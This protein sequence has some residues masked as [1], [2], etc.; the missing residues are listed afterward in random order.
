[1]WKRVRII[2]NMRTKYCPSMM[3]SSR[4]WNRA[5]MSDED[6]THHSSE[7]FSRWEYGNAENERRI[8]SPR[9]LIRSFVFQGMFRSDGQRQEYGWEMFRRQDKRTQILVKRLDEISICIRALETGNICRDGDIMSEI[10]GGIGE[11]RSFEDFSPP[12]KIRPAI[13]MT[14]K[15]MIFY[16][17]GKLC[18]SIWQEGSVIKEGI[19]S[20]IPDFLRMFQIYWQ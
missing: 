10:S 9:S 19:S 2:R 7:E 18:W 12:Y 16:S 4:S 15:W 1:M 14:I 3:R 17:R 11:N 6:P 8:L 13:K 20:I 5:D